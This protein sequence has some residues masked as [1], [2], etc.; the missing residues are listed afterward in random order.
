MCV[1]TKIATKALKDGMLVDVDATHGTVKI[2][3]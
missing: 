3:D 1:G 2:L